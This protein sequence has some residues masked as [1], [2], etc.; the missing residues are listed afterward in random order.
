MVT[1]LMRSLNHVRRP[2]Q[3]REAAIALRT[4]H[5]PAFT[6]SHWHI[7]SPFVVRM[8]FHWL[9]KRKEK[10]F[11]WVS[12]NSLMPKGWLSSS[13]ATDSR[14]TKTKWEARWFWLWQT[15]LNCVK[16]SDSSFSHFSL[17]P[18][19][20][21][22]NPLQAEHVRVPRLLV[23]LAVLGDGRGRDDELKDWFV[24][25]IT[26]AGI[27]LDSRVSRWFSATQQFCGV[28]LTRRWKR[29]RWRA[30]KGKVKRI[31]LIDFWVRS[32]FLQIF[33]LST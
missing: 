30:G 13:R 24:S 28:F 19:R 18:R 8:R 5:T 22:S 25:L 15:P 2:Q 23:A 12:R 4:G 7:N 33:I 21:W 31:E 10:A 27:V 9:N 32:S 1:D 16:G 20:R 3:E 14:E 29:S 17:L 6:S 26:Q 11:D